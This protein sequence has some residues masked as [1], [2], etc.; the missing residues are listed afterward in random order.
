MFNRI[1][2][3]QYRKFFYYTAVANYMALN[4]GL[5]DSK[6]EYEEY[7]AQAMKNADRDFDVANCSN[8][9]SKYVCKNGKEYD[10]LPYLELINE[11]E[12][13]NLLAIVFNECT[14]KF[15]YKII[16]TGSANE[17]RD[18]RGMVKYLAENIDAGDSVI[19]IH[20]H[21]NCIIAEA[22]GGDREA[23]VKHRAI[24]RYLGG[25]LVDEFVVSHYD[26]YSQKQAEDAGAE[27]LLGYTSYSAEEL[28]T[29]RKMNS[30][31][32]YLTSWV[33]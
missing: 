21:P 17:V 12:Y 28:E 14:G 24:V 33:I 4:I 15:V 8:H 20:N 7:Y 32:F 3:E 23:F 6:D 11:D 29:I 27:T 13:E 2:K 1:S 18:N 10:L 16:A 25:N 30:K 22:S 9:L 19:I 5:C 26:I 31:L